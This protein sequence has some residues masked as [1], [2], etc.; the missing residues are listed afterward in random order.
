MSDSDPHPPDDDGASTPRSVLKTQPS[1]LS[2]PSFKPQLL[3]QHSSITDPR[4]NSAAM[5]APHSRPV[6]IKPKAPPAAEIKKQDSTSSIISSAEEKETQAK[7]VASSSVSA[8]SEIES[9]LAAAIQPLINDSAYVASTKGKMGEEKI[10]SFMNL[11]KTLTAGPI[12]VL[13]QLAQNGQAEIVISAI[14][15]WLPAF[16]AHKGLANVKKTGAGQP[17]FDR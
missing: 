1:L 2:Q 14:L 17:T 11:T 7:F 16:L 10:A 9:Q 5:P 4:P 13:E 3:S 15:P 8:L 12:F 6:S